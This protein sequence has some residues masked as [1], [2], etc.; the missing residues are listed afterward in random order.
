MGEKKRK[1]IERTGAHRYCQEEKNRIVIEIL[2][3][4]EEGIVGEGANHRRVRGA[5]TCEAATE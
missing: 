5:G 4:Q 2:S 3:R 1:E